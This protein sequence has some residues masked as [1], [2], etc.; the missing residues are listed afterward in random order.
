[1]WVSVQRKIERSSFDDEATM[2]KQRRMKNDV[3]EEEV[4]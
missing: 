4:R 3:N 2:K 1:M